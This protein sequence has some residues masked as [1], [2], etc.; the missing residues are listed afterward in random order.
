MYDGV[1]LTTPRGSGTSGHV[2]R[3]FAAVSKREKQKNKSLSESIIKQPNKEILEHERKRQI[4]V[5]CMELSDKL[6]I[7][8]CTQEQID[9]EVDAYRKM[10]LEDYENGELDDSRIGN[11]HQ[12]AEAQHKR[13]ARLEEI[14]G[15]SMRQPVFTTSHNE[16][17]QN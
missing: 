17:S 8:G 11:S 14:F 13:N 4:E 6:E 7:D 1:G 3:N 5:E 12:R 9:T 16:E 10:R 15:V 2:Q